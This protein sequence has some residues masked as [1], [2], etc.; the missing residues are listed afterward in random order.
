[1]MAVLASGTNKCC[2]KCCSC[3]LIIDLLVGGQ[4]IIKRRA[5]MNRVGPMNFKGKT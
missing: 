4:D 1:M 5:D 3:H 2:S